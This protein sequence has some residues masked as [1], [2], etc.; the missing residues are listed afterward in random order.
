MAKLEREAGSAIEHEIG[1]NRIQ[2]RP[3]QPLGFGQGI[4][5]R[6]KCR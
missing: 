6:N 3:E 5:A 1:W 2:L 4:Q